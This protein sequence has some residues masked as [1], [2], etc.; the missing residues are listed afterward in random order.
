VHGYGA[1]GGVFYRVLK[2]LSLYFH[3]YVIDLLG[4]GSSG[5]PEYAASSVEQFTL[6]GIALEAM[7]QQFMHSDIPKM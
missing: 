6:Q 1:G 3:I 5:R 4:M 2:D 7:W